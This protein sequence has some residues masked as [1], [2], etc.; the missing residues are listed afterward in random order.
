MLID[1]P[2][3]VL[4]GYKLTYNAFILQEFE[5]AKEIL[6]MY[7]EWLLLCNVYTELLAL[8]LFCPLC[9]HCH[10]MNCKLGKFLFFSDYE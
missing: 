10:G 2:I 3:L 9:L 4:L 7:V 1:V 6:P 5:D 8:F